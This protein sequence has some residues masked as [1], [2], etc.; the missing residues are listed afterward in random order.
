MNPSLP[1]LVTETKS[2][3]FFGDGEKLMICLKKS[4]VGYKKKPFLW[5]QALWVCSVG[6]DKLKE[7]SGKSQGKARLKKLSVGT[8]S[9][10]KTRNLT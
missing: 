8:K 6:T 1:V 9:A 5:A 7:R 2:R 4:G 3:V 10:M